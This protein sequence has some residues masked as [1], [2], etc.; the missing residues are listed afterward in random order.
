M[1]L[2]KILGLL[3][4]ITQEP[5]VCTIP[6]TYFTQGI[7]GNNKTEFITNEVNLITENTSEDADSKQEEY[8]GDEQ[9]TKRI[10]RVR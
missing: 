1:D 6:T 9:K 5:I 7:E 3:A 4:T 10:K 2:Y 8:Q